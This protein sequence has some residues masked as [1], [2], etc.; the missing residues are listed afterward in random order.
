MHLPAIAA[1][2][3]ALF[4][5]L[6]AAKCCKNGLDY[7]GSGLLNKG[8]INLNKRSYIRHHTNQPSSPSQAITTAKSKPLSET[9]GSPL[10]PITSIIHCSTV[11]AAR[12]LRLSSTAVWG[13]ARMEVLGRMITARELGV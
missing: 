3:L 1:L 11:A 9:R 2:T 13:N 8:T 10:T 6:T 4:G 7:C 12:I 5:G